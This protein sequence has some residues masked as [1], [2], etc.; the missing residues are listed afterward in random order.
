MRALP[1]IALAFL[2]AVP[3][4]AGAAQTARLDVAAT[5]L[6]QP[7]GEPWALDLGVTT[8]VTTP[9]GGPPSPLRDVDL[10]FP[11]GARVDAGA[12]PVCRVAAA[13]AGTCPAGS[14][15]GQ[16]SAT[17]DVRPLLDVPIPAS[18]VVYNGVAQGRGRQLLFDVRTTQVVMQQFVLEGSLSPASGRYGYR[19]ALRLPT[20]NTIPD[21]PP[22]AISRFAVTVGARHGRRSFISA[23]TTCPRGGWPF[24]GR[25]TFADG[26][27]ASVQAAIACTLTASSG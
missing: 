16:G 6:T 9:D 13:R 26:S 11:A 21:S 20:I 17:A 15:V 10:S 22:A 14:R 27:A 1:L 3:A 19:L 8:T 4:S 12:F 2:V 7:R 18:I 25:Y 23:P 24:A 5:L